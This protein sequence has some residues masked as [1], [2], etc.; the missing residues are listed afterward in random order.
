M[1][2][3][4]MTWNGERNWQSDP[5]LAAARLVIA[6]QE[7]A[8]ASLLRLDSRFELTFEDDAAAVFVARTQR[9]ATSAKTADPVHAAIP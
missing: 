2:K 1:W 4:L 8:L 7:T 6:S 5:E 3:S 9:S